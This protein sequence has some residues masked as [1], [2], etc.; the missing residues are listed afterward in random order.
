VK[1][2]VIIRRSA[3]GDEF[4]STVHCEAD[5]IADAADAAAV[6]L[7]FPSWERYSRWCES[8]PEIITIRELAEWS[9]R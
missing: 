1:L 9:D 8:L 7:G 6:E 4:R 2:Q 3:W 5:R